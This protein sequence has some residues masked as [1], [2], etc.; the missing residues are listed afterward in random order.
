MK[1]K[2]ASF[3][4][5]YALLTV[6]TSGLAVHAQTTTTWTN[7]AN[8]SWT[9]SVNWTNSLGL[10]L[11]PSGTGNTA[12]FSELTLGSSLVVTLDGARTI[13]NLI[14]GDLGN[15]YNWVL[16]TGSGG[17]AV[18]DTFWT[19]WMSLNPPVAPVNPTSTEGGRVVA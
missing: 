11:I 14:F 3:L 8:G 6:L 1:I 19:W 7:L 17:P 18:M 15:T 9:N 4:K 10:N 16:G 13:G 5:Y 12:D 2:K